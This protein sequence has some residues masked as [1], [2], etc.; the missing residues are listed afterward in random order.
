[1]RFRRSRPAST[2]VE[3]RPSLEDAMTALPPYEEERYSVTTSRPDVPTNF[4]KPHR[5]SQISTSPLNPE[6]WK[7]SN[8]VSPPEMA[9]N[10]PLGQAVSPPDAP[11]MPYSSKYTPIIPRND[12]P[13][14]QIGSGPGDFKGVIAESDTD[15]EDSNHLK[16]PDSDDSGRWSWTNSQAPSTPRLIAPNARESLPNS[17]KE[18]ARTETS[19]WKKS[20]AERGAKPKQNP[21]AKPRL[22][23]QALKPI[24]RDPLTKQKSAKRHGQVASFSSRFGH[25]REVDPVDLPSPSSPR[26]EDG[27][28]G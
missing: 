10:A 13:V 18:N 19:V 7:S 26:L 15:G 4:S 1:M 5:K 22:K 23:N 16:V 20:K 25:S 11:Y 28:I 12:A 8:P 27:R 21:P 9:M 6:A 14:A 24:L 17:A 2:F 3:Q